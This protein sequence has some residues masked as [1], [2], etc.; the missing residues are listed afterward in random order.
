MAHR[1]ALPLIPYN[2]LQALLIYHYCFACAL[3][4]FHNVIRFL[5]RMTRDCPHNIRPRFPKCQRNITFVLTSPAAGEA[6]F[7]AMLFWGAGQPEV[8]R[9]MQPLRYR[10]PYRRPIRG[11]R[12][13]GR[14]PI[15][16]SSACLYVRRQDESGLI[17]S[18]G[19]R[20]YRAIYREAVEQPLN[21][22]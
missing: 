9:T 10:A 13:A 12:I 17:E 20:L 21:S 3:P 8:I 11:L 6:R 4:Y 5:I 16:M 19:G 7:I 14:M 2:R 15:R 18:D 22:S 1:T